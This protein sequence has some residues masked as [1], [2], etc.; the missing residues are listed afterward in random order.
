MTPAPRDAASAGTA[1]DTTGTAPE[2]AGTAVRD[3]GHGAAR[4]IVLPP[5]DLVEAILAPVTLR[6]LELSAWEA[7]LVCA[8]RNAVLAYLAHRAVAARVIDD[9]PPAPREALLA[10]QTASARLAQLA[11]FELDR[12][13]RE[14]QPHGIPV[15][16]LKG[17]A[18]LLR[19]MPHA[20][21]R[22]LSDID[23]MVPRDRLDDAERALQAGGWQGTKVDAYDQMY[24][25]RWSH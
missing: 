7:L 25:R 22:I 10:A 6:G 18:Y 1:R 14:L 8:R 11:R 19:G 20:T 5:A 17:A 9:V 16:A 12:V 2:D 3:T 15:I 4:T 13:R 21:T 24:Y 23:V